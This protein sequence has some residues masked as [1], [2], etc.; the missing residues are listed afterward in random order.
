[1]VRTLRTIE[2]YIFGFLG[3]DTNCK[4]RHCSDGNKN[5]LGSGIYSYKVT[6]IVAPPEDQRC[7]QCA[8]LNVKF[9]F[10]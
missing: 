9:S 10:F 1:M 7:A 2:C 4:E 6:E 5:C 8:P 3:F